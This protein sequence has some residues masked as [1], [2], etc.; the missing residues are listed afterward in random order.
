MQLKTSRLWVRYVTYKRFTDKNATL[1]MISIAMVTIPNI[2][3]D[4]GSI[5]KLQHVDPTR[6]ICKLEFLKVVRRPA[7]L[8]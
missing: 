6:L 7:R 1:G 2:Y 3:I 5:S 4:H 8:V